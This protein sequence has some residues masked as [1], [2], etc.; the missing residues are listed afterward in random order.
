MSHIEGEWADL[1]PGESV[2]FDAKGGLDGQTGDENS[3]KD[4][5]IAGAQNQSQK[6]S[7]IKVTI[8]TQDT[9]SDGAKCGKIFM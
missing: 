3:F 5:K 4:I 9:D 1:E 7:G 2:T 8:N 6:V